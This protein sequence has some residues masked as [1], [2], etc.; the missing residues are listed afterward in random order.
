MQKQSLERESKKE[1]KREGERVER[2]EKDD[3]R[4]IRSGDM[5][6]KGED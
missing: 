6:V 2:K 3:S 4:K 5:E 1:R